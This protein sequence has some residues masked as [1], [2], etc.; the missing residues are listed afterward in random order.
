V[1]NGALVP[2]SI[3]AHG[4]HLT[5]EEVH[6]AERIGCWLVQNPRSNEANGV[7]YPCA[8]RASSRVALGTDGFPSNIEDEVAAILHRE[9]AEVI[10]RRDAAGDAL[11]RELG[12]RGRQPATFDIDAIRAEAVMEAERLLEKMNE[13]QCTVAPYR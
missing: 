10:T 6:H 13:S 12:L 7:G 8:L 5:E 3:L 11:A 2:L 1:A 4:V 9:S